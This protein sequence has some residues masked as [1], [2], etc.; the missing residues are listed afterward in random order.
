MCE[1]IAGIFKRNHTELKY[2]QLLSVQT[3]LAYIK[4]TGPNNRLLVRDLAMKLAMLLAL[5]MAVRFS[6]LSLLDFYGDI[7]NGYHISCT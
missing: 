2:V 3:V 6:D 1:V 5:V 7:K 4:A